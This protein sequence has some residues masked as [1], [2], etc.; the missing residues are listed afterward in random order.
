ML[1]LILSALFVVILLAVIASLGPEGLW[2]NSIMLIN[3]IT[4]GLLASNFFE[5]LASKIGDLW[6]GPYFWDLICLWGIFALALSV[7]RAATDGAS[8]VRVKFIR[9]VD[10]AGSYLMAVWV[11]WVLVCFTAASLH[12]AP[13]SRNF[14]FGGFTPERKLFFGL[15]PDRKWLAFVQK[16]SETGYC[17]LVSAEELKKGEYVFDADGTFMLRYARRR[18]EYARADSFTGK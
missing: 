17:R 5:P 1:S 14:L 18:E 6:P 16:M 11:G 12:T 3:V 7:L 9:Q 13:L 8:K 4:A 15:A 10:V 2:S